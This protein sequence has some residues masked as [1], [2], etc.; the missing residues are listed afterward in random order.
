[1]S[2]SIKIKIFSVIV[3]MLLFSFLLYGCSSH[4]QVILIIGESEFSPFDS[5]MHICAFLIPPYK[6]IDEKGAEEFKM[7]F[8]QKSADYY[9]VNKLRGL[10]AYNS[11]SVLYY[12]IYEDEVYE[13]VKQ[14]VLTADERLEDAKLEYNGYVFYVNQAYNKYIYKRDIVLQPDNFVLNGYNDKL[15]LLISIG[16][17]ADKN[18]K[19]LLPS[20]EEVFIDFGAFLKEYFK[21]YDFDA[22]TPSID[23]DGLKRDYGKQLEQ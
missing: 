6:D 17:I 9:Y 15:N 7:R 5:E 21:F 22:E 10:L 3:V 2:K 13:A 12:A 4:E 19:N 20:T 8:E 1:M 23:V 18:E 14:Y 11:E 16:H